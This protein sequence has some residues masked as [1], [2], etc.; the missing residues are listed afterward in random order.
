MKCPFCNEFIQGKTCSFCDKENPADA[1]YCNKCGN[2]FEEDMAS[3]SS[4]DDAGD[5]VTPCGADD[6]DDF[7]DIEDRELCP[8][9]A[10][11]GII[12]N[13]RCTECGKSLND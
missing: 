6:M 7:P 11:T 4:A 3:C 9:G 13:N 8:D 2:A 1:V 5:D 12:I 10:C